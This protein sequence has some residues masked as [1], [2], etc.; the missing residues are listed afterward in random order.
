MDFYGIPQGES[1]KHYGVKGMKW[2]KHKAKDTTSDEEKRMYKQG[3]AAEKKTPGAMQFNK[4]L[5]GFVQRGLRRK[6]DSNKVSRAALMYN[7]KQMNKIRR[8]ADKVI[9]NSRATANDDAK[10]I[11]QAKQRGA[12]VNTQ[13]K[14]K[15]AIQRKGQLMR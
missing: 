3:L 6:Y 15:R 8:V 12:K 7:T 14:K 4:E 11:R 1:L 13:R 9:A 2:G 5:S 10:Q